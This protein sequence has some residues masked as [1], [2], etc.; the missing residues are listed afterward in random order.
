MILKIRC[1]HLLLRGFRTINDET[2]IRGYN[3]ADELKEFVNFN[4]R[5][6]ILTSIRSKLFN[7]TVFILK[8]L[9]KSVHFHFN[10]LIKEV[11]EI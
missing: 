8:M 2:V 7:Y 10:I 6:R 11:L 5:I 9:L 4:V 3:T 1:V